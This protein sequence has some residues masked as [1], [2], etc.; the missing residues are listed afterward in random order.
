MGAAAG[1]MVRWLMGQDQVPGRALGC[2][3]KHIQPPFLSDFDQ[4][5]QPCSLHAPHPSAYG[6]ST[7]DVIIVG[8][9]G[10][11]QVWVLGAD[12]RQGADH[13]SAGGLPP[14]TALHLSLPSPAASTKMF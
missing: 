13:D 4:Q 9:T 8:R 3:L 7:K 1:S 6:H 12:Q 11:W 2:C 5:F 14:V 10:G